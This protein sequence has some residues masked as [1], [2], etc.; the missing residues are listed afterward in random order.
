MTIFSIKG[1]VIWPFLFLLQFIYSQ[2]DIIAY[3][4]PQIALN[5][6][7]W[8]DYSHNFTLAN[9]NFIYRDEETEF[10]VRQID[11]SHYSNVKVRDN[12]SLGL[13]ILW[14]N[15]KIFDDER[16]NELRLTEQYNITFTP[17]IVR[18][19]HRL[20]AEQRFS[21]S[22][23]IFRFRYRFALDFPLEGEKLDI[24]ESYMVW[25]VEQ[26]LSAANTIEPI[27]N[28]RFRGAL[29]WQISPKSKIQLALEYRLQNYTRSVFHVLLLETS[30]NLGI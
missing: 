27:Y 26:L 17:R 2:D 8:N 23:T 10:S 16:F 15:S 13:G 24:G 5:Y 30:L 22:N 9:R 11:I 19:G 7:V 21:T 18:Y 4:Q 1:K 29:G 3:W 28:L 25:S 14:R 6:K 12:Q 20:R